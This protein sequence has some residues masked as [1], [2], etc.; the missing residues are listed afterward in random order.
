M[1]EMSIGLKRGPARLPQASPHCHGAHQVTARHFREYLSRF[2]YGA[3]F[4]I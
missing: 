2:C 3:T 1:P 4:V